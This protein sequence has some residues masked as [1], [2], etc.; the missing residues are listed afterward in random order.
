MS[1][2]EVNARRAIVPRALDT[3][4][5]KWDRVEGFQLASS[6]STT[7][8][9]S[10]HFSTRLSTDDRRLRVLRKEESGHR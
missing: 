1:G 10:I 4:G 2:A 3:G 9:T 6:S 7:T 5:T 8:T